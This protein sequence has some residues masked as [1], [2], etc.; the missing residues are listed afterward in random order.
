MKTPEEIK[1]GLTCAI[2]GCMEPEVCER[3]PYNIKADVMCHVSEMANDA[4]ALIERLE[5]ER[6]A[7]LDKVPKSISV[8][9]RLP[10]N[11][12]KYL[13]YMP[14]YRLHEV[15]EYYGDGEWLAVDFTNL[16]RHV[17][18]WMPLPEPPEEEQ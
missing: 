3:C 18:H 4:I 12:A 17:S 1:K 2:D 5:S 13:V 16:T 14:D 10:E 11:D 9:E 7:A 6:D 15:A 8:E